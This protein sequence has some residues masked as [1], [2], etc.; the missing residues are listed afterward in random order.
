[1]SDAI[2]QRTENPTMLDLLAFD[3]VIPRA[4]IYA[5]GIAGRIIFAK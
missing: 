1:M 4:E 2:I 3:R 5:T